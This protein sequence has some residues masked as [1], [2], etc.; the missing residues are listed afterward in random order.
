MA[1]AARVSRLEKSANPGGSYPECGRRPGDVL[2]VVF[3][4]SPAPGT[5][6]APYGPISHDP[7]GT[8]PRCPVCGM[9]RTIAFIDAASGEVEQCCQEQR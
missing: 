6:P 5:D 4:P 2:T 9:Y 1:L 3:R 7:G 8:R